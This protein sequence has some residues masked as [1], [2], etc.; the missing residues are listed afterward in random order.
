[1]RVKAEFTIDTEDF[2]EKE[3]KSEIKKLIADI[4]SKSKLVAFV[5]EKVDKDYDL[6]TA[7]FA[8]VRE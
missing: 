6:Y 7:R 4:D 5:M 2:G 8:E 1:M 3:F